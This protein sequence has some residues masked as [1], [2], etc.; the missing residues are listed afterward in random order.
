VREAAGLASLAL[1]L[2]ALLALA[3][4]HP[5]DAAFGLSPA[6]NAAGPFGATLAAL[7]RGSVGLGAYVVVPAVAL[8]GA[9]LLLGRP[10]GLRPRFWAAAALLLVGLATIP[11]LVERLAPGR[12]A[13]QGGALGER[14]AAGEAALLHAWGALALNL[15]AVAVA[16]LGVCGVA[17]GTALAATAA[18]AAASGSAAT[19]ALSHLAR[20]AAAGVRLSGA[21]LRGAARAARIRWR[22]RARRAEL[23]RAR[24]LEPEPGPPL[25]GEPVAVAAARALLARRRSAPHIVDHRS[26]KSPEQ[27]EFSFAHAPAGGP[28]ALPDVELFQRP[29]ERGRALDR[30]SLIM[31]SRILEKKLLDFGVSGRV[32]TVHPGPVITMYEFEPA[33][34]VKVNRITNLADD[35]ALAL[36]ALSVRI[37]APIPGKSVVGIEV[38]N[39]EREVVYIRDLLEAKSFRQSASKL[40]L[41]LGKDIFGNPVEADLAQ[42]PHLL[43]AG[44][45]GT[46]K[47]VFLNSL[48]CSILFRATP[49]EVKLLLVDP[50][51]LELSVYEGIPHLIADVVTNPKRA[52]AALQGIVQK[53]EERY[54]MMAALGVR[55][56]AQF[57]DRVERALAAGERTFR[58]RPRPGEDQGP[59]LEYEKLPYIVV[60]IDELADLMVVSAR[61][62]E[63][64]LQRLAQMARAAGIHLVLATQRP[65]V[66]VLTGVIKANFPARISFQVSSRTDSRTILDANG[67]EHLLGQGDMLFLPPGTSKL[68]RVHGSYVSEREVA[69]L[70][71]FLRKQGAPRFDETL[72]RLRE[73]SEAREEEDGDADE[74]YGRAVEIVAESRNASISYLQR[75]LKVGYNRAA[76]M[77]ERMEREGLVGAQD[78]TK[79]REVFARPLGG[80]FE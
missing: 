23:A 60:V 57:N 51:L 49:D 5:A 7:L 12:L 30:D 25:A 19:R 61:D 11:P 68:Q 71:D 41:A 80:D 66:D 39:A 31:N 20:A 2:I 74:L 24:P 22:R 6:R 28:F 29:P 52:A 38:P 55:N 56:I 62:V 3:S 8:A 75:R 70:V 63:E 50:K 72:I 42:M 17:P 40:T 4:H 69:K 33:S 45:T 73:E 65:S 16:A 13:A 53:M 44:A 64:S 21:A 58:L 10:L 67:A 15:L 78:G 47:S 76:R 32:V 37:I 27:E 9:R 14:L 79:G 18:G 59:A 1:A 77:I 34:G 48:L 35:L 54:L 46:G 36:R 43:V 26:R